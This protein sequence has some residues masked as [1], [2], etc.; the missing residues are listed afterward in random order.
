MLANRVPSPGHGISVV[1]LA[2]GRDLARRIVGEAQRQIVGGAVK[3]V[4][5]RVRA[6]H[7]IETVYEVKV[8]FCRSGLI[9]HF[10][11]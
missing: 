8:R 7:R 2:P 3:V 1:R 9:G 5:D 10:R 6:R 4:G 11:P